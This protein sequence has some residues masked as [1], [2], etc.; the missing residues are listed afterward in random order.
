MQMLEGYNAGWIKFEKGEK[1]TVKGTT[2]I[3]SVLGSLVLSSK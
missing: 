3:E 2:T 1:N